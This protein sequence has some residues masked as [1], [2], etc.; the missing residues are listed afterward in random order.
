MNTLSEKWRKIQYEPG[1][2]VDQWVQ[3]SFAKG[4]ETG[5]VKGFE[6]ALRVLKLFRKGKSPHQIS[7]I[8]GID[9]VWVEKIISRWLEIADES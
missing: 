1:S 3:E 7:E 8:T 4:F 5:F 6:N 9:P 2:P